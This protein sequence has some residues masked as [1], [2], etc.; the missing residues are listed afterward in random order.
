MDRLNLVFHQILDIEEKR[1]S[2]YDM[3]EESAIKILETV[4]VLLHGRGIALRVFLDDGYSRQFGFARVLQERLGLLAVIGIA[5]DDVGVKGYL[6]RNQVHV[7]SSSGQRI[8]SHGVSHAA[9]G[10][11]D[12]DTVMETPSGGIYRNMPKG[13][14]ELL[15]EAEV[16]Y[17]VV[18]SHREL[19]RYGVSVSDFIYPY[20]VYNRT[21]RNIVENSNLYT[22]AHTC[23]I[24]LET[25][26][27]DLFLIPRLVID[28][29]LPADQWIEKIRTLLGG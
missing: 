21:I 7:L 26:H 28:N 17:Q 25:E 2:V 29:S 19:Q 20:G 6:T 12:N 23:D 13:R 4:L 16:R 5:T 9:L 3:V 1:R 18:E 11:Y 22:T 24:V 8:A 14:I 10:K 27:S 15:S